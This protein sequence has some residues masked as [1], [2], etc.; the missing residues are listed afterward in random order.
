MTATD[1]LMDAWALLLATDPGTLAPAALPVHIHLAKANFTPS[2]TLTVASF[3][4]ADFTGYAARNAGVGA[5]QL[6]V[7]PVTGRRIVQLLEP[8][9]GWH[10]EVTGVGLLP[11]TM[12]GFFVTDNANL[13]LFGSALLST[14]I[15]LGAV[16]QGLSLA[17]VRFAILAGAIV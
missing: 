7:D 16:A 5:Q 11:Q 10:W 13:V 17:E 3:T 6:F 8:A 2:P 4:E 9:G 15:V 12:F 14:P 1:V